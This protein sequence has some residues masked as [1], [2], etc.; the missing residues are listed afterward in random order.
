MV[1]LYFEM[2]KVWR[3]LILQWSSHSLNTHS[4]CIDQAKPIQLGAMSQVRVIETLEIGSS[5][6][7]IPLL[8]FDQPT[9]LEKG[10]GLCLIPILLLFNLST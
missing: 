10:S 7:L 9:S 1:G 6:G 5:P 3:S 2:R 8:F 4:N